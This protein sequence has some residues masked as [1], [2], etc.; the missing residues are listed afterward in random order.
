M[1]FQNKTAGTL[2]IR[3]T[4]TVVINWRAVDKDQCS[5][6]SDFLLGILD[7]SHSL[8]RPLRH[9]SN[10]TPVMRIRSDIKLALVDIQSPKT[11]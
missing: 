8:S 7:T 10:K 5:D 4:D 3:Q 11:R 2:T 9:P 6:I 1:Q